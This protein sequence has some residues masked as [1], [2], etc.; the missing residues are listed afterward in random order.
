[1]TLPL[2][3]DTT[4]A[5]GSQV[6]SATLNRLQ[7]A[8]V[9]GSHGA[10]TIVIPGSLGIRGDGSDVDYHEASGGVTGAFGTEYFVPI[11]AFLPVGSRITGIRVIVDDSGG[12]QLTATARKHA[13][14][15]GSAAPGG[16]VAIGG[17]AA[18]DSGGNVQSL[19]VLSGGTEVV[20]AGTNYLVK[21][22]STGA[23]PMQIIA[24]EVDFD[25]PIV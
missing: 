16:A 9:Q 8:V 21:V 6:P 22:V 23:G 15:V 17:S 13:H 20:I 3:R 24:V 25:H 7:D 2:S 5:P 18:S 11:G 10:R 12:N 1:M 14:Q 19:V 4:F